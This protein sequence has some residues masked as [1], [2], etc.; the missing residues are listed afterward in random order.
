MT[1][2]HGSVGLRV[3]LCTAL[4]ATLL[5]ACTVGPDYKRAA[6]DTPP[7]WRTDAYWQTGAPSHAPLSLD[8]WRVFDDAVLNDLEQRLLASNQSLQSASAHYDEARSSLDAATSAI[9]PQLTVN[10]GLAREKISSQ[11]PVQRY[12]TPSQSTVQNDITL[13]AGVSYEVD[14]FGRVRR[15]LEGARAAVDQASDDLANARLVL[16]ANLASTYFSLRELD[17][18]IDIVQQSLALQQRALDYVTTEHDLGSVSGLD[19]MQQRSQLDA[20]RT[21]AQLLLRQRAQYEHA[22]AVLIGVPA[23]AFSVAARVAPL[24]VPRIDLTLPSA[25][26]QRRPDVASAERAMAQANARIGV[27]RTAYFPDLTLSPTIGWESTRFA[28]MLSAPSLLWSVGSS[29]G[30]VVFDGGKRRAGVAFAQ[31]DYVAVQASYRQTV[32]TAFQEVQDGVTGLSVLDGAVTQAHSAVA[33]AEKLLSLAN[34]RY[35][36]GLAAYIDVISAQEQLLNSQRQEI[37]IR[38]QQAGLV[39]YLVKALGGGW[40]AAPPAPQRG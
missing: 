16:T 5:T 14:L 4:G 12:S 33:D 29:L 28:S 2:R 17:D 31:Q 39:V 32:L 24:P 8:W 23:P 37:Q 27:A 1:R 19:V 30:E 26:L 36:G 25:L 35:S 15:T 18:E 38:G 20:N 11:R 10:S 13:E 6:V 34:D 7:Q 40:N 21:Q 3:A 22:I 9:F